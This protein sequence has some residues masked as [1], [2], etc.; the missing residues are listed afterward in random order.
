MGEL[1]KYGILSVGSVLAVAE[2]VCLALS[3]GLWLHEQASVARVAVRM[4]KLDCLTRGIMGFVIDR[5]WQA[6]FL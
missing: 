6:W 2:S 1:E 4:S 5:S 3:L